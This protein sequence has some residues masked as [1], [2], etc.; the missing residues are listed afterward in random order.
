MFGKLALTPSQV[1][2]NYIYCVKNNNNIHIRYHHNILKLTSLTLIVHSKKTGIGYLKPGYISKGVLTK[3][4]QLEHSVLEKWHTGKHPCCV[5]TKELYNYTM[6]T[7]EPCTKMLI[8]IT[9]IWENR[10]QYG[11]IYNISNI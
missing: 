9:G 5:I 7:Q 4:I 10:F 11:L 1:N 6:N 2:P 3:L 8:E